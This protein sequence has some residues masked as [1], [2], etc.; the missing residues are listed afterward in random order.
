MKWDRFM[1]EI[2]RLPSVS[3]AIGLSTALIGGA[4]TWPAPETPAYLTQRDSS[5]FSYF[6]KS[7]TL[8]SWAQDFAA[9]VAR[10]YASLLLGQEP[11]GAEFEAIWDANVAALY[12]P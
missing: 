7:L 9:G 12:E 5:T 1:N 11:L 2:V 3:V 4:A 6:E 8:A 10:V